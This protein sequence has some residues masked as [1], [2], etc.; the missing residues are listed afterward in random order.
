MALAC[1]GVLKSSKKT[2]TNRGFFSSF[3]EENLQIVRIALADD[4]I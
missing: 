2:T 4:L 3:L 1:E